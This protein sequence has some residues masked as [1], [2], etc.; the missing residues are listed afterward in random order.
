M[1][2]KKNLIFKIEPNL[3]KLPSGSIIKKTMLIKLNVTQKPLYL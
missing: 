1:I 3:D 2:T